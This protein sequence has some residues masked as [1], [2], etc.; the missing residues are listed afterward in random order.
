M[1]SHRR[2]CFASIPLRY[3][4][5]NA[6]SLSPQALRPESP[7]LGRLGAIIYFHRADRSLVSSTVNLQVFPRLRPEAL[8]QNGQRL[9][10]RVRG[11]RGSAWAIRSLRSEPKPGE[12]KFNADGTVKT[13]RGISVNTD[14]EVV[15]KFG[16]AY[17]IKMLP[18]E[19]TAIQYGLRD[20]GHYE[21]VPAEEGFT[22]GEVLQFLRSIV[23]E[24]PKE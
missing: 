23:T 11:K 1:R 9:A 19:L 17:E 6:E 10:A 8:V 5:R 15:E 3:V 18:P 20:P 24:G 14:P 21:L 16:G 2:K 4:V 22:L 13:N 12:L 7:I